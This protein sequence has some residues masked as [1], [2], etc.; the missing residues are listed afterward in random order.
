MLVNDSRDFEFEDVFETRSRSE[1][2]T[3][4][5]EQPPTMTSCNLQKFLVIKFFFVVVT[6]SFKYLLPCSMLGVLPYCVAVKGT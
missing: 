3:G 5:T 2:L 1:D 6:V 4:E